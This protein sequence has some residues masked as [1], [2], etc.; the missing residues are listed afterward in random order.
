VKSTVRTAQRRFETAVQ[1][2]DANRAEQA[3]KRAASLMDNAARKGVF[4]RNTASR[5][6]SRMQRKLNEMKAE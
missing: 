3:F 4:H 6:K 5:T 2:G 1:E